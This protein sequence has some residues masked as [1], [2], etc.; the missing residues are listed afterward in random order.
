MRARLPLFGLRLS[1]LVGLAVSTAL[2]WDYTRPVAA[3]CAASS[4][5]AAVKASKYASLLHVPVPF[6]G[7]AG[8]ALL[9]VL[10]FW[11]RATTVAR[12]GGVLAGLAGIA[13]IVLQAVVIHTFC[14]LCLV[15]DAASIVVAAC[16]ALGWSSTPERRR[17][18]AVWVLATALSVGLPLAGAWLAPGP[19]LIR[20]LGV[21]GKINVV[22]FADFECPFCR[23]L[24]P[25]VSE[26][27]AEYGN[28]VHFVRLNMPL[29][30]HP[31]ARTAARAYLCAEAQG[32][33]SAMADALFA[34]E[35]LTAAACERAAARAGISMPQYSK[36]VTRP[37][38]DSQID[39]QIRA[40]RAAGMRGLPTLWIGDEQLVGRQP[41]GD[42]R[43]AFERAARGG[44]RLTVGAAWIWALLGM[45]LL[46][47]L[48]AALAGE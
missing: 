34:A 30:Q 31:H 18:I 20:N 19:E 9:A 11:P 16:A 33:G 36:C 17:S 14:R 28:S 4:G 42:V 35:D 10:T 32:K 48:G 46:A 25:T 1:A 37:D 44:H 12:A 8:F 41:D 13:F 39:A 2:A 6:Y 40:V 45:V 24:H 23:S 27:L 47:A 3:F 15:V 26:I 38:I 5:C 7:V 29:D 43:A 22:E 21:P